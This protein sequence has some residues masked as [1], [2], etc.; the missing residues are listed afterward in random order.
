ML[1]GVEHG[2]H[3]SNGSSYERWLVVRVDGGGETVLSREPKRSR[4][5]AVALYFFRTR[6]PA[7]REAGVRYY[8]K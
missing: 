3:H 4:A 2:W 1:G 7:Q 6:L 5:V 8:V